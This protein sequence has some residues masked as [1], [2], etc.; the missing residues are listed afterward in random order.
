MIGFTGVTM[1]LIPTFTYTMFEPGSGNT[2]AISLEK[3]TMKPKRDMMWYRSARYFGK[4]GS[5]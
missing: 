4:G 1:N 2:S 3:V 5:V